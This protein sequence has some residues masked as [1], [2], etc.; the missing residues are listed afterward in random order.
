MYVNKADSALH[1]TVAQDMP[2]FLNVQS[3][4]TSFVSQS[5]NLLQQ[6]LWN[7]TYFKIPFSTR[8]EL[9]ESWFYILLVSFTCLME[10][11]AYF[12]LTFFSLAS[13]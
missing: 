2:S 11:T 12:G 7:K 6:D 3:G 4:P 13:L 9:E 1:K 5:S 8:E 10:N